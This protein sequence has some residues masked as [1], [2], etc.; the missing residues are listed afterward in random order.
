MCYYLY[1]VQNDHYGVTT[2]H[3]D[4]TRNDTLHNKLAD[5]KTGVSYILESRKCFLTI[6][7]IPKDK[8]Q[9]AEAYFE[10]HFSQEV[11]QYFLVQVMLAGEGR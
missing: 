9:T 11:G 10:E 6:H 3:N 7:H 2:M 4:K 8:Q 5:L 1:I